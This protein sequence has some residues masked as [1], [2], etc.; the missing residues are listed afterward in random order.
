M[1]WLIHEAFIS[2]VSLPKEPLTHYNVFLIEPE[3]WPVEFFLPVSNLMC[4][5]SVEGISIIQMKAVFMDI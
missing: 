3:L 1:D 5:S 4:V 2:Q